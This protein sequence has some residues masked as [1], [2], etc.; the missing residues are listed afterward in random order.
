MAKREKKEKNNKK[1]KK[2]AITILCIFLAIV[3]ALFA[4]G[5]SYWKKITQAPP[6]V[7]DTLIYDFDDETIPITLEDDPVFEQMFEGDASDYKTTVKNWVTN[8]GDIMYSKDVINVLCVGVDTR[9]KNTVSGLTDSMILVSVNTE[10]GEITFTSIMRDSYAYLQSP[11]GEGSF[12]KIN[13][14][15]P[16]YGIE[17]LIDTVENHFKVRIDGYAMINFALFKAVIDKFG[18]VDVWVQEY[19]ANYINKAYGFNISYGDFVKLNGDEALAFCRSRKC[20]SDGDISRTRRQRQVLLAL[21]NN[22]SS[23][24]ASEVAGYVETVMPYLKTNYSEAEVL[25]LGTRAIVNGWADYTVNQLVMPDE[26]SRKAHSG[27]VW[28]WEVDY[29]LAAQTLQHAIY[30]ET[31]II[32]SDDRGG[33]NPTTEPSTEATTELVTEFTTA[34]STKVAQ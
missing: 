6:P 11:S 18:G 12:N 33:N 26:D 14:A 29:P 28:Y 22:A 17:N 2:I 25:T 16:F 1:G 32:L 23:I 31:N 24:Q 13:S 15:F 8:G 4:V 10:R 7:E 19:E 30:G 27:S 20:D 21:L 3:I 9:N 5:F 34:T